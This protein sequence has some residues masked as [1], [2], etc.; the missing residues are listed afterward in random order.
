MGARFQLRMDTNV[1]GF[2]LAGILLLSVV[3]Q[4]TATYTCYVC[5]G[6]DCNDDSLNLATA[7][8]TSG[9]QSCSK[10]KVSNLVTRGCSGTYNG[11]S[12]T[13]LE[14]LGIETETCYCNSNLCNAADHVTISMATSL[15]FCALTALA[16]G[17]LGF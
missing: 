4:T 2:I 14:F 12:C 7:T 13:E 6:G 16:K 17:F 11:E 10:V 3:S 15:V 8:Q 9:C 5:S 1:S